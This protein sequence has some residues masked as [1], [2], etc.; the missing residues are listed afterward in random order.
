MG[1]NCEMNQMSKLLR[2]MPK[3][4]IHTHLIGTADAETI[5]KIAQRNRVALPARSL[6][7]WKL[8]YEFRDFTHFI[9]VYRI[10]RECV[11]TPDDYV[12]LVERFLKQQAEQ[13]IRYS[14]VHFGTALPSDG[15][16]DTELLK[17]LSI[18]ASNGEAKYG[19]RVKFI[20]AIVRHFPDLQRQTLECALQGQEMGIVIGLGLAGQEKG[21]APEAFA[22]TF[23][24]ARRQGLRVV[25]HAGE[26]VGAESI[27]SALERLKVERIGHGIR[28]LEDDGLVQKL[29][30]L[31]I[32]LEVSPQSNYCLGIVDRHQPHPIRQLVDAGLFCTLNSDDPP[33][34]KT[35]LVNEYLTLAEQGFSWNELWQLNLNTLEASFLPELEKNI[36]RQEWQEFLT[37][38][39]SNSSLAEPA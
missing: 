5:Y 39:L 7:E 35:D 30:D 27:W 37:N 17:A 38:H 22:E 13:N 2:E 25:A 3:V 9:E 32:P 11:Q 26:A 23:A 33:M 34:F 16:T 8:F 1:A 15:L 29:C 18:G 14:E 28:C 21:Y 31:Q 19:S 6:E 12:F 4:E 36:Y 10:A 24:E 20:A